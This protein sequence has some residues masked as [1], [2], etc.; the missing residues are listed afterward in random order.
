MGLYPQPVLRRMEA[1]ATRFVR[2]V[3]LRAA[4]QQAMMPG[5]R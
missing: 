2:D 3:D 1:S 4:R 5:G